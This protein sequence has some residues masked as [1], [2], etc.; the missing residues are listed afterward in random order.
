MIYI[1]FR[2]ESQASE[3]A[4]KKDPV[5]HKERYQEDKI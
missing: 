2:K 3:Q 4:D 5:H 1:Q